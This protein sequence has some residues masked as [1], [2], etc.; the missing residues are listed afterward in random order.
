MSQPQP[1]N[2]SITL[3]EALAGY[4]D[5]GVMGAHEAGL[6]NAIREALG[7]PPKGGPE[8]GAL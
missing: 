5:E 6:K 4:T 8:N 1:D 2:S 7:I 3:D